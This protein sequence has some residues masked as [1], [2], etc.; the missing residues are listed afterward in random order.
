MRLVTAF[1]RALAYVVSPAAAAAHE[2]DA[3]LAAAPPPVCAQALLDL[4]IV[5]DAEFEEGGLTPRGVTLLAAALGRVFPDSVHTV[6]TC[7]VAECREEGCD[8]C[9]TRAAWGAADSALS[10]YL[11]DKPRPAIRL[12]SPSDGEA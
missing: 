1:V 11:R 4:A 3:A 7:P 12:P 8:E 5:A 10:D 2:E 6:E 9:P